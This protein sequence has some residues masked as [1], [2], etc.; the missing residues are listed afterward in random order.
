MLAY[1]LFAASVVL[2]CAAIY[3]LSVRLD[4]RA[5]STEQF[6][7]DIVGWIQDIEDAPDHQ[8]RCVILANPPPWD[9]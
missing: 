6:Q 1:C 5:T 7:R 2:N 4:R 9:R 8:S 3:A